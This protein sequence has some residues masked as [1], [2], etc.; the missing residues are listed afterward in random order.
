MQGRRDRSDRRA[1]RNGVLSLR[2]LSHLAP[3]TDPR[4]DAVAGCVLVVHPAIGMID[5]FSV[6]LPDVAF[7]PTTHAHYGEK[8]LAM[9]DGLPKCKDFPKEFAGSGDTLPE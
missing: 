4:R 6:V 3:R 8:L 9:R 2:V 7:H 5:V 1:S